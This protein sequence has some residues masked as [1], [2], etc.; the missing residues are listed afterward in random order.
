MRLLLSLHT[1]L[2]KLVCAFTVD[3]TKVRL[4]Y[5]LRKTKETLS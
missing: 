1:L 2:P 5:P 4:S 3:N